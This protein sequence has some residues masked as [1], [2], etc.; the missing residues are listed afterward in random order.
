MRART[1]AVCL[2]V[3]AVVPLLLGCAFIDAFLGLNDPKDVEEDKKWQQNQVRASELQSGI[4]REPGNYKLTFTGEPPGPWAGSFDPVN[5]TPAMLTA[6]SFTARETNKFSSGGD[7]KTAVQAIDTWVIEA[8]RSGSKIEGTA[9]FERWRDEGRV[10]KIVNEQTGEVVYQ[11]APPGAYPALTVTWEGTLKAVV[12]DDGTIAGT[13]VGT[14]SNSEGFS[15]PFQWE[16]V[17][18]PVE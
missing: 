11:N 9:K 3:V 7:P 4:D 12:G 18:D 8:T 2:F 5:R 14:F 16:F 6:S 1:I 15:K 17:G 10:E 13:V